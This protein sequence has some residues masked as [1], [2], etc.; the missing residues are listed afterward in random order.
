MSLLQA[1]SSVPTRTTSVPSRSASRAISAA[2]AFGPPEI[3][4][5]ADAGMKATFGFEPTTRG[6]PP[7][8]TSLTTAP[9]SYETDT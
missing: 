8:S 5:V 6:K 7:A 9:G 1:S 3:S 2:T 4:V